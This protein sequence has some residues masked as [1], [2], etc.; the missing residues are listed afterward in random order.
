MVVLCETQNK[1]KRKR[2]HETR[3]SVRV[4]KVLPRRFQNLSLKYK[5]TSTNFKFQPSS[6]IFWK[7]EISQ[8]ESL[9][10][11]SKQH[12]GGG[13]AQNPGFDCFFI[14]ENSKN[15]QISKNF[16]NFQKITCKFPQIP[17]IYSFRSRPWKGPKSR[18]WLLFYNW[19][20]LKITKI[21]KNLQI[22]KKSHANSRKSRVF[23][24]PE[25]VPRIEPQ[26]FRHGPS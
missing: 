7:Y 2:E 20:L 6:W 24:P 21:R 14:I 25:V 23:T 19:K 22:S 3:R 11:N 17:G 5:L 9:G 13:K 8:K 26:P 18:I 16:K 4:Y 10:F 12:V 1:R 15:L